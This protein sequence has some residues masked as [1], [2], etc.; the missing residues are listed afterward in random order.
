MAQAVADALLDWVRDRAQTGE[1]GRWLALDSA[2]GA[3]PV[4]ARP[5]GAGDADDPR[6]A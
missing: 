1:E 3:D 4:G 2:G 5:P 6:P